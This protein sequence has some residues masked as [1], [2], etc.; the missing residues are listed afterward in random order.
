MPRKPKLSWQMTL[1]ILE[2]AAA[3]GR[4]N[5]VAIQRSMDNWLKGLPAEEHPMETA[6]DTR[7]IRRV[8]EED[9]NKISPETVIEQLPS[10]VWSLRKDYDQ[11]KE[12]ANSHNANAEAIHYGGSDIADKSPSKTFLFDKKVFTTSDKIMSER[13]LRSFLLSLL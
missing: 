5:L 12:L 4:D 6:P 10:G 11:I 1:K 13:D 2:Y 8:I 3:L 7:T 9:L